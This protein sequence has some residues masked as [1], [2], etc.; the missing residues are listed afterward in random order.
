MQ[1]M[2][3]SAGPLARR[4]AFAAAVAACVLAAALLRPWPA[5]F[6]FRHGGDCVRYLN[7]SHAVADKG[8]AAFPS[9]CEEYRRRW[10]GFPPPTRWSWLALAAGLEKAWR[11]PA[12]EYHP[13]VALAWFPSVLTLVALALWLKR[14][15]PPEAVVLALALVAVSPVMRALGHF[16]VPDSLQLMNTLA[17]VAATAAWLDRPRRWLLVAVG[18]LTFLVVT[19]RETG[20]ISAIAAAALVAIDRVRGGRWRAAPIAAMLAGC[21]VAAVSTVVLAGGWT[22]FWALARDYVRGALT[23]TGNAGFVSG[24]YYRY[25]VDLMIASPAVLVTAVAAIGPLLRTPSLRPATIEV[26]VVTVVLL[27][28][29]APLPKSLRYVMAA[30]AGLRALAALAVY[31]VWRSS[32]RWRRALAVA[33]AATLFGHDLAIYG[34]VFWRDKTYD[35]TTWAMA[36]ALGMIP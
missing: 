15:V 26:L 8:F 24:P 1:A 34:G 23:A 10:V 32:L 4:G 35:P 18:A 12:D 14:R 33:L 19:V 30:E 16:P 3:A 6:L 13:L 21:V 5:T 27:A 17:L 29:N 20:L 11:A 28:L 22:P 25:L 2:G 9:L 31:A 36:R 7:W